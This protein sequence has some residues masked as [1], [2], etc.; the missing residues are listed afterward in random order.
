MPAKQHSSPAEEAAYEAWC[1]RE[2]LEPGHTTTAVKWHHSDERKDVLAQAFGA[3]ASPAAAAGVPTGALKV[4]VDLLRE[5]VGPLEVSAAV[6]EDEDGGEA[7]ETLLANIKRYVEQF[8]RLAASPVAPVG[9]PPEVQ[10]VGWFAMD[11]TPLNSAAEKVLA[12]C[13]GGALSAAVPPEVLA[14]VERM[15]NPLH[16]SWISGV[17]AQED[18]RRMKLIADFIGSLATPPFPLMRAAFRTTFTWGPEKLYEMRFSFAS[19][20]DLHAAEREWVAEAKP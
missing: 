2:G 15:S 14:A 4:A 8:D 5:V 17:T 7:M 16:P 20:A 11:G 19:L 10:Y 9:V 18:A 3:A 12:L 13:A 1:K 6:I